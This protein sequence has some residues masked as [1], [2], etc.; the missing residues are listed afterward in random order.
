MYKII[1][2]I[3]QSGSGKDTIL[4]ELITAHPDKFHK[5]VPCTTRPIRENE[6]HGKSYFFLTN[7]E[8]ALKAKRGEMLEATAFN[9]WFY[10][11]NSLLE[12]F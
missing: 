10:G 5:I 12:G 9:G 8:F 3:G 4:K 2:L 1:A 7:D 6:E 11:N